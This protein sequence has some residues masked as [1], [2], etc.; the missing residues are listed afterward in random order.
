MENLV[1]GIDA[2]QY[3]D[4][5]FI[6]KCAVHKNIYLMQKILHES[7]NLVSYKFN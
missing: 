2:E 6:L 4:D 7:I 5:F 1:H 3:S